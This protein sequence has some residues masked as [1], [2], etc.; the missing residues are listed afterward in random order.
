LFDLITPKDEKFRIAFY[1]AV[2]NTI[3]CASIDDA[4]VIKNKANKNN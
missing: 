4:V 3:V 1:L 2:K